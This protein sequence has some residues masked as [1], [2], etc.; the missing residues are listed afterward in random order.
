MRWCGGGW[1]WPL[2]CWW[3]C[4]FSLLDGVWGGEVGVELLD[5]GEGFVVGCFE[6]GGLGGEDEFGGVGLGVGG[7]E[8]G[9]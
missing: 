5:E 8:F 9:G 2:P 6:G 4:G 1:S 7:G 3:C